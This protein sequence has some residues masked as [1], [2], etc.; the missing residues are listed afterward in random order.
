MMTQGNGLSQR[1]ENDSE[2]A[3]GSGDKVLAVCALPVGVAHALVVGTDATIAGAELAVV[4]A[5]GEL[6]YGH[7]VAREG[8]EL[9]EER[10]VDR[11]HGRRHHH[12]LSVRVASCAVCQ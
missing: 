10:A 6:A 11:I 4:D 2:R 9:F 5:V 3:V 7:P 1:T 8:L 12:P